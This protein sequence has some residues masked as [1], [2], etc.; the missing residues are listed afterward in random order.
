MQQVEGV[1]SRLRFESIDRE[2]TP[3]GKCHV[4]VRLEWDGDTYESIADGLQTNQ[5]LV[6]ASAQAALV[7]ALAAASDAVD[8]DLVGVK[9][10]RAF[11]RWVVVSCLDGSTPRGSHRVLGAA[12]CDTDEEL[13]SAA[14][15]AV[16]DA[17]NRILAWGLGGVEG[18]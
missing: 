12:P 16:L 2:D 3:D 13:P 14:V 17:S 4:S 8:L 1:R 9:P 5:G 7:A 10:I 18:G 6:S 11:D 15:R